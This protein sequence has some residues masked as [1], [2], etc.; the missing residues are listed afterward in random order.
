MN[1]RQCTSRD[2]T[3]K[4]ANKD[5]CCYCISS[6]VVDTVVPCVRCFAGGGSDGVAAELLERAASSGSSVPPGG[7]WER[8]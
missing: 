4:L 5:K 8:G 7:L 3:F 6:L 2:G 1:N